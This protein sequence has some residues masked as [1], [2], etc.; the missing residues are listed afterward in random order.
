[1]AEIAQGTRGV[2]KTESR[3]LSAS[4]I[5][6]PTAYMA[7]EGEPEDVS[8]LGVVSMTSCRVLDG[9]MLVGCSR[10]YVAPEYPA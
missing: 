5:Q 10:F 4:Y 8:L 6:G 1:M 9:T 7:A 3:A 2:V